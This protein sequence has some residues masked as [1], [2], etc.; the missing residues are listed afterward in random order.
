MSYKE[1]QNVEVFKAVRQSGK[2]LLQLYIEMRDERDQLA[3]S[4]AKLKL[5]IA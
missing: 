5:G 2:S 3:V 4:L 1:A